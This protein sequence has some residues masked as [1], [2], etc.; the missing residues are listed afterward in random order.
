MSIPED[1]AKERYSADEHVSGQYRGTSLRTKQPPY[2]FL[3]NADDHA[4]AKKKK[5]IVPP[6]KEM[7]VSGQCKKTVPPDKKDDRASGQRR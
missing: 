4:S 2:M 1:N 5:P 6:E 7:K 3:E